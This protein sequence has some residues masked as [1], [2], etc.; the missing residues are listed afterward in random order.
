MKTAKQTVS[1]FLAIAFLCIMMPGANA[2]ETEATFAEFHHENGLYWQETEEMVLTIYP[3]KSGEYCASY[4]LKNDT[5]TVYEVN[6]GIMADNGIVSQSDL[7]A[8]KAKALEKKNV[9]KAVST[10]APAGYAAKAG[11]QLKINA[12]KRKMADRYGAAYS[13]KD[14][15]TESQA[16]APLTIKIREDKVHSAEQIGLRTLSKGITVASGAATIASWLQLT[17]PQAIAVVCAIAGIVEAAEA[18]LDRTI[19]V[20]SYRGVTMWT[21]TGTVIP[22]NG[23]ETPVTAATRTYIRE[24]AIDYSLSGTSDS[25]YNYLEDCNYFGCI[26]APYESYF[27]YSNLVIATYK[28]YAG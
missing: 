26:Y 1:V 13:W 11:D 28:A 2:T 24:Y 27:D 3:N 23:S 6:T 22:Q 15:Y 17:V 14:L 16:Y 18:I 7:N 19:T 4:V 21:R 12:V 25:F 20:Q 9:A 5:Y 8:I 10:R